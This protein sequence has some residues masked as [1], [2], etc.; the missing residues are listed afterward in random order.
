MYPSTKSLTVKDALFPSQI[1][2]AGEV[3]VVVV[4]VVDANGEEADCQGR[5]SE[6]E[7]HGVKRGLLPSEKRRGERE[8]RE[9]RESQ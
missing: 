3:A 6:R 8:A 1:G 2:V 5:G 9:A 7:G 4:V